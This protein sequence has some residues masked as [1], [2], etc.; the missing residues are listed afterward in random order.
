M[1]DSSTSTSPWI[2]AEAASFIARHAARL[3]HVPM[4]SAAVDLDTPEDLARIVM[5]DRPPA[6]MLDA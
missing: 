3:V 5:R 4:P 2:P 1:P 6:G